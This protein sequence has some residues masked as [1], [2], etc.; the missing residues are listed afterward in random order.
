YEKDKKALKELDDYNCLVVPGGFGSRGIEGKILAIQ[1]ARENKIPYLGLCYGMQLAAIEFVRHVCGKKDA[2]TTE[3]DPKT[4]NP[5]IH[6]MPEQAVKLSKKQYGNTM[7]LGACPCILKKGSL[8]EKLY[9]KS[10]ISERHRHRYEFNNAFRNMVEK[11]GLV[12][13]GTSPDKSLV[14]IIELAGHP[15]F[16]GVQFHPELKSRPLNPHPLFLGLVRAGM[17]G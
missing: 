14:E 3:I 2:H 10:R 11:K 4:K 12:L 17:K 15:F 6:I 16:V 7:R 8:A 9:G 5:V 13:S 1:Y